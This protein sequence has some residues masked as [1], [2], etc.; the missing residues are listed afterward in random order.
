MMELLRK[1]YDTV[2]CYEEDTVEMCR[3]VD[4]ELLGLIE[5]YKGKLPDDRLDMIKDLMG[6]ISATAEREGFL[7]GVKYTLKI[8][9]VLVDD[10]SE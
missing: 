7:L 1:I 9:Y 6:C 4:K 5:P 3:R 8:L 2:I 10:K